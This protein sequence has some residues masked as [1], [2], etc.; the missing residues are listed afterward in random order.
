MSWKYIKQYDKTSIDAKCP[1]M[2]TLANTP[3]DPVHHQEGDVATHTYM[4]L[5]ALQQEEAFQNCSTLEQEVL[6]AAAL[7]HDIE[8]RSTTVIEAD[9]RITSRGH[10]KKGALSVRSMLYQEGENCWLR[11]EKYAFLDN[12][13]SSN[14][15][16]VKSLAGRLA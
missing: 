2:E 7:F 4:V 14:C 6:K 3:Q 8:K 13:L 5:D 11:N 10:A 16:R 15:D 1:W 12:S 9:G